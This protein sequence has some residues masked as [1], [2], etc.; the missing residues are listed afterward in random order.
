M[1]A[2]LPELHIPPCDILIFLNQKEYTEY[3]RD[4]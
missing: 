2:G 1:S 4:Y 3:G